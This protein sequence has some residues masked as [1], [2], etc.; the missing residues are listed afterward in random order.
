MIHEKITNEIQ[1]HSFWSL[2]VSEVVEILR[3]NSQN[4]ISEE[5]A[6]ERLK[7]FG[8]NVIEKSRQAPSFFILLNQFKSPLILILLFAGVVTLF[9]A[10]YRDAFFI[11]A[12][13][14]ANA[15]LGFYQ[16]YKAEKALAELKTHLK[17]R[18]RVIRGG[19]EHEIDAANLVPG[20]I[21]RLTQGDL[22]RGRT[23]SVRQ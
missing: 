16:E 13:L 2:S 1:K 3:T 11:F 21:I 4:G 9:L 5:E 6:E 15:T 23:A 20:D 7:I 19:V 17:Q 22:S 18:S 14:I 8:L 10:H 12:A